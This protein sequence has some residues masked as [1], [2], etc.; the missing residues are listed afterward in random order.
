MNGL[1]LF[2]HLNTAPPVHRKVDFEQL[3]GRAAWQR[4]VPAIRERF[5]NDHY[6]NTTVNYRGVMLVVRCNTAGWLLAQVCRL[7][8]TPLTPYTGIDV[9]TTVRVYEDNT[10]G[11][12]VWEREYQFKNHK[13]LVVRSVKCLD[14]DETLLESVDGG[15]RMRLRVFE[16]KGK[17]VF[18]SKD[19]FIKL[20][21]LRFTIPM[22]LTPGTTRVEHVDEGSGW[23]RFIL[24]MDHPWLGEMFYQ[25]GVFK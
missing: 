17:L 8:G 22:W 9:A 16:E 15:I 24:S 7:I 2:T 18:I 11:G 20:A 19:Y 13:P 12:T 14:T 1:T 25:E 5:A 10:A 23:F 4:L 6:T 3:M 21:G